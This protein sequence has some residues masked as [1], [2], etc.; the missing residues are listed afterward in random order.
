MS[1]PH[2][3]ISEGPHVR[4]DLLGGR[5]RIAVL[6]LRRDLVGQPYVGGGKLPT[7]RSR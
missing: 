3:G 2:P 4:G 1:D 7:S 5:V 6:E